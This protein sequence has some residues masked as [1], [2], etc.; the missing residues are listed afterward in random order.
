MTAT[1]AL[2]TRPVERWTLPD[3]DLAGVLEK[4][5]RW[6]PFDGSA[7]LDDVEILLEGVPAEDQ[8]EDFAE[9]LRGYS[10]LLVDIALAHGS[11]DDITS[12][13]IAQARVVRSEEVPGGF[14]Q[15]VGLLRRMALALDA[16]HEH[17]V[18]ARCM[19]EAV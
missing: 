14:W 9:R 3:L 18:A 13:L 17:L 7:F 12:R 5:Q 11:Q 2:R 10:M 16:L 6:Q 15:A 1:S 8:V 4:L 19:K